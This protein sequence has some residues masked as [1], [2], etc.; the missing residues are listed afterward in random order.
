MKKLKISISV[1]DDAVRKVD[2]IAERRRRS[3]SFIIAEAIEAYIAPESA[4]P[5]TTTKGKKKEGKG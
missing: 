4:A 5:T 1:P 2:E 3:R